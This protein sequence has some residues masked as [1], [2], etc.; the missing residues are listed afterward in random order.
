MNRAIQMMKVVPGFYEVSTALR[1]DFSLYS[2][3][4]VTPDGTVYQMTPDMVRDGALSDEGW[5]D[6]AIVQ[7]HPRSLNNV[8]GD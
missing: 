8:T 4:E 7:A 5:H 1:K 3:V 6:E 2:V